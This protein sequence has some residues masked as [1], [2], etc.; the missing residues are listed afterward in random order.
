MIGSTGNVIHLSL[1]NGL[2]HGRSGA[3]SVHLRLVLVDALEE[4]L[5]QRTHRVIRELLRDREH[6]DSG[7]TQLL[8]HDPRVRGVACE[9]R[10]VVHNDDRDRAAGP[11]RVAE[12]LV[13]H[14]AMSIG[15]RRA[16]LDV[17]VID[18]GVVAGGELLRGMPL[19]R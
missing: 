17:V 10:G 11:E 18:D 5:H 8:L 12:Q 6:A 2:A 19:C 13:E 9:A 15:A 14:D 1:A 4:A 16:G 7:A 3:Q